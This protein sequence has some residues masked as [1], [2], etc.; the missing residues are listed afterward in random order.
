MC[1]PEVVFSDINLLPGWLTIRHF[2]K[3]A[4]MVPVSRVL[5]GSSTLTR[6]VL[7]IPPG[8]RLLYP[9]LIIETDC[10][11]V[12][13]KVYKES[14]FDVDVINVDWK[15]RR[16]EPQ[17][18]PN[19]RLPRGSERVEEG[20]KE[21]VGKGYYVKNVWIRTEPLSEESPRLDCMSKSSSV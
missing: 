11:V 19:T 2:S 10:W 8:R 6:V 15:E 16:R 1:N 14:L 5:Q 3:D 4:N 20:I 13:R 18:E 17:S 21:N 9:G 12:T 7:I